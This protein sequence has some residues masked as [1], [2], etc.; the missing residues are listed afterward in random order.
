MFV[1]DLWLISLA[2]FLGFMDQAVGRGMGD[3]FPSGSLVL[4]GIIGAIVLGIPGL[5]LTG[6]IGKW[7]G[8]KLGGVASRE[9]VRAATV[10]SSVPYSTVSGLALT[11]SI[12][13]FGQEFFR[14]D[15]AID[16]A[17]AVILILFGL[18]AVVARFWG[19]VIGV[20]CLAEVHKFSVWRA[21]GAIA[22]STVVAVPLILVAAFFVVLVV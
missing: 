2:S 5:Y 8:A 21:L 6:V 1:T 19:A 10:W 20:L 11:L 9:E 7:A 14:S 4:L 22:L 12:M 15:T 18:L 3:E 13:M 16:T 17:Q